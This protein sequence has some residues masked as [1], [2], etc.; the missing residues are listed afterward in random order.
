MSP[1]SSC[2]WF[3]RL[4]GIAVGLGIPFFSAGGIDPVRR[5]DSSQARAFW[6]V[7][8]PRPIAVRGGRATFRFPTGGTGSQTLVIVSA[9]SRESGPF[10]IRL[11][12]RAAA[13]ATIPE[14]ADDGPRRPPRTDGDSRPTRSSRPLPE[15]RADRLPPRERVFHLMV[16]RGDSGSPGNYARVRGILKAVGRRVQVYVASEDAE[17]VARGT[18]RDV[19]TTFD[20]RIHTESRDRLGTARDVD[21]DGR[22]TILFSS[23]LDRLGGGRHAVDGFVKVA[24]L[25]ATVPAPFGNRCDMM[26][27]NAGLQPGPYLRTL[28]AHEYMHAVVY[29]GKTLE[30]SRGTEVGPEEEAWLDE[31]MAHLAEDDQGFSPSNIDYRVSAFLS[32]PERYR[33]VVDDYFAA[34]LFRSHGNRGSTYLFLRWCV[35]RYGPE[36]IPRLVRSPR[37]GVANIEAATGS[38][39][40]DLYRR[41][42]LATFLS[43][44]D[45]AS[46]ASAGS[47]DAFRSTNLYAPWDDWELAG[48]RYRRIEPGEPADCWEAAGTSSHFVIVDGGTAGAVEVEVAGPA[49]ADLQVTALP[50]EDGRA[51]V[52]LSLKPTRGADGRRCILAQV[53]EHNGIP[54]RLSAFSW[55]PLVPDSAPHGEGRPGGR[56]DMLGIADAF[57]SSWLPARG[58]LRS[59]VLPLTGL[60]SGTRPIVVKIIGTDPL[61]RRVTAW[62]ELDG[63]TPI[64][65]GDP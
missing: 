30:Q 22:F 11:N 2:R 33:L 35:D 32:N 15:A 49:V 34:N 43:G 26:Y 16:G 5:D 28:L 59:R 39:F 21:G 27:L 55:E 56:I 48:P 7:G 17:K 65:P 57:G 62:A 29:T 6:R 23:W 40:A 64:A 24:D 31:A 58:D 9:L 18:L 36:L 60:D 41:W 25:D 8:V 47:G 10:P 4:A 50:L 51:R 45:P 46:A 44:L 61:G 52:T 12:A 13:G 3:C 53:A 38:T 20:D 19:V 42:S 37:R 54:V 14:L 1:R 63:S